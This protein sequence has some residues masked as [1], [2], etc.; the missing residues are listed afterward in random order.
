[1]LR[2]MQRKDTDT[3][4]FV[5]M[6]MNGCSGQGTAGYSGRNPVIP[7]YLD[8]YIYNVYTESIHT[9]TNGIPRE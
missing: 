3:Q 5:K 4:E 1:M 6:L 7:G 9:G 2:W 8:H